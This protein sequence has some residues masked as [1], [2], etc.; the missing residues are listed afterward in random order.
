[1]VT[2]GMREH[3]VV[4]NEDISKFYH[5]VEVDKATQ[6]VRRILWRFGN[7]GDRAHHL[8][9]HKGQLQGQTSGMHSCRGSQRDSR[10]VWRR[11]REGRVVSEES[12]LSE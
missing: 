7:G 5:C 4:F 8:R 3:K 2:L 6:H 12:H 1:M 9:H 10:K 11:E